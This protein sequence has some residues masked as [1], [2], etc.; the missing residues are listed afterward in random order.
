MRPVRAIN[1]QVAKIK[2]KSFKIATEIHR[3]EGSSSIEIQQTFIIISTIKYD[4]I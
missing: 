4:I 1:E 3:I 2:F